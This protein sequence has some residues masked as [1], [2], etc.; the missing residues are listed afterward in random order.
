MSQLASR[1]RE[2]ATTTPGARGR[3]LPAVAIA[4]AAAGL[5]VFISIVAE[6]V[7]AGTALFA[8]VAGLGW[9]AHGDYGP[10]GIFFGSILIALSFAAR[11]PWRWTGGAVLIM[12]L[13]VVQRLLVEL[14][15]TGDPV[16]QLVA[17]IHVLNAGVILW[18]GLVLAGRGFDVARE[19]LNRDARGARAGG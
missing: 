8:P 2:I 15:R 1:A 12:V 19:A 18:L 13:F 4:Y 10:V 7:T 16:L 17:A 14:Y 9:S 3:R 5:I 11:Q 6:F